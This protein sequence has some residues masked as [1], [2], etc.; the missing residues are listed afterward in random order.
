MGPTVSVT[1]RLQIR[2]SVT[3][4]MHNG[5]YVMFLAS[6]IESMTSR[7]AWTVDVNLSLPSFEPELK[8]VQNLVDLALSTPYVDMPTLQFVSSVGVLRSECFSL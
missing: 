8:A 1:L 7:I 4:I 6:M 5:E 3:H 2:N